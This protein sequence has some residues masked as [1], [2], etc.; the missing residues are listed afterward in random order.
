MYCSQCGQLND[1]NNYKCTKCQHILHPGARPVYVA[2]DANTVGGLIPYHNS[3]AL[4]AY[5]LAI[6]SLIPCIGLLLGI[7]AFFLGLQGLK[8]FRQHP[9]AKGKVHA[10][11][12]IIMGGIC[13]FGNLIL[14]ILMI[15]FSRAK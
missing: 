11:I 7:P 4:I 8:F 5:Y 14:I 3:R 6:F 12:G 15:V 2:D 10:W 1:D 9:E 13:G